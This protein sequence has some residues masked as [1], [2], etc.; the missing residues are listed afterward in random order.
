MAYL[1][2][3]VGKTPWLPLP[4]PAMGVC[5]G[6]LS[7]IQQNAIVERLFRILTGL[8]ESHS[9]APWSP[10]WRS[11]SHWCSY[12][13]MSSHVVPGPWNAEMSGPRFVG[14]TAFRQIGIARMAWWLPFW[15]CPRAP[16]ES[17]DMLEPDLTSKRWLLHASWLWSPGHVGWNTCQ[18]L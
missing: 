4:C 3:F 16:Q 11:A 17:G 18:G 10:N 8:W 2:L 5:P 9:Y 14:Q 13:Q 15:A 6:C 1:L 7:D 12:R